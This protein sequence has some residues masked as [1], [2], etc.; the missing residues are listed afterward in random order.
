MEDVLDQAALLLDAP[1]ALAMTVASLV[2]GFLAWL[3]R[4]V[5][6]EAV[7]GALKTKR[8]RA[9]RVAEAETLFN[10]GE[11]EILAA[12]ARVGGRLGIFMN[13]RIERHQNPLKIS[14]LRDE[15][16]MQVA[17]QE[18]VFSLKRRK[19][20]EDQGKLRYELTDTGR[21]EGEEMI[22]MFGLPDCLNHPEAPM[23]E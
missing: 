6:R 18:D 23:E 14:A 21:A 3:F 15:W 7:L 2:V 19:F 8:E 12:M 1:W 4:E 22:R 13:D 5:I 10:P 11:R 16:R 20:I 9:Q 17:K